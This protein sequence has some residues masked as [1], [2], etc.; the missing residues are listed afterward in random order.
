V[1]SQLLA[2]VVTVVA[3][4]EQGQP[5][6][7]A[8]GV[9]VAP[10]GLV[11]TIAAICQPGQPLLVKTS[12]G[13]IS[14]CQKP[15]QLDPLQDLVVLKIEA[16][17]LK[18]ARVQESK[19]RSADGKICYPIME[20]HRVSLQEAKLSGALPLS[21]RLELLKVTASGPGAQPG[22]PVFNR[23]GEV[24]GMMHQG[25]DANSGVQGKTEV[26]SYCLSCDSTMLQISPAA[27]SSLKGKPEAG[28]PHNVSLE[29]PAN[30]VLG[31]FWDGI[32]A[33]LGQNWAMAQQK[34][35]QAITSPVQLPEAYYGRGVSRYH[36]GNYP[37]ATK[38]FLEASRRLPGYALAFFWLGKSW[39]KRG[40]LEAAAAAYRQAVAIAPDFA[41][42]WFN[43]GEMAYQQGDQEQAQT[44]LK[45]AMGEL[46]Q[47]ARRDWYLGNIARKQ[48]RLPEALAA[49]QQAV[50]AD[51]QFFPAFLEGGQLLL[52][53]GR[54]KEAAIWLSQAVSLQPQQAEAR[55]LLAL[56]Y[57]LSWNPAAA[58]EQYAA[59]E[60]IQPDRARELATLLDRSQ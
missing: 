41:E 24:I 23:R 31:E 3:L 43:L 52:D 10:E 40:N 1:D 35:A 5:V 50:Q 25:E 4:D 44:S 2:T 56:T 45:K 48:K 47:R 53:L 20:N 42:A 12:C 36:L 55:Y 9:I 34:F 57:H 26:F 15:V 59:L 29:N 8:L 22:A 11:L 33:T 28:I 38:D 7:S 6:R 27:K 58:W 39:Q 54:Y 49:F 46:P 18:A 17:G 13:E 14:W 16:T 37:G 51:P 60:K 32:A 30:A 21:P 19:R